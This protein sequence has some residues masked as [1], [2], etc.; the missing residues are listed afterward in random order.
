LVS[1]EEILAAMRLLLKEAHV[2]AEPS[3]AASLAGLVNRYK[4][5][6]KDENVVIVISGGNVSLKLLQDQISKI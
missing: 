4:P 5:R 2:L 1:D 3:G 6:G